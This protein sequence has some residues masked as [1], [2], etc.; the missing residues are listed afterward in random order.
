MTTARSESPASLLGSRGCAHGKK[1][2]VAF[3]T[4]AELMVRTMLHGA[5]GASTHK[6]LIEKCLAVRL[7]QGVARVDAGLS[8]TPIG[9]QWIAPGHFVPD[10]RF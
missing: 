2:R 7:I 1:Q 4:T 8:E 5:L 9:Y 6:C 3:R 10:T